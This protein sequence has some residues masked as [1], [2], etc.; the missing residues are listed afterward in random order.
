MS[1]PELPFQLT[2]K[3]LFDYLNVKAGI[4]QDFSFFWPIFDVGF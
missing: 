3:T 2:E 1:I 4:K